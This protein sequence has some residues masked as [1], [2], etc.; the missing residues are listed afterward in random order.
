[1]NNLIPGLTDIATSL[2]TLPD[3][4]LQINKIVNTTIPP[5]SEKINTFMDTTIPPISVKINTLLDTLQPSIVKVNTL[6]GT[7]ETLMG[8]VQQHLR[9]ILIFLFICIILGIIICIQLSKTIRSIGSIVAL[10]VFCGTI[11]G[12]I[13]GIIILFFYYKIYGFT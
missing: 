2:S 5:I 13:F 9:Q 8:K 11:F 6:L 7:L 12:L 10:G 3:S 1:M 4:V